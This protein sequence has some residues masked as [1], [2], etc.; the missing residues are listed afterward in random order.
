MYNYNV[1]ISPIDREKTGLYGEKAI[2]CLEKYAP[3]KHTARARTSSLSTIFSWHFE[4][5]LNERNEVL[6][7]QADFLLLH[8]NTYGLGDVNE[9]TITSD[10]HNVSR[11]RY[12]SNLLPNVITLNYQNLFYRKCLKLGYDNKNLCWPSWLANYI[13]ECGLTIS[14]LPSNILSPGADATYIS[15]TSKGNVISNLNICNWQMTIYMEYS[16]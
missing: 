2:Q 13:E 1:I 15:P 14:A 7:H 3:L 11:N 4:A 9:Y 16:I 6:A 10:W 5:A 12:L 8:A